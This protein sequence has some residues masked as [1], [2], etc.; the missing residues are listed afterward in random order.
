[1]HCSFKLLRNFAHRRNDRV[2]SWRCTAT[3]P[4]MQFS[5]AQILQQM[6]NAANV[7]QVYATNPDLMQHFVPGAPIVNKLNT[8][9]SR[10]LANGTTAT[11]YALE[12][13]DPEVRAQALHFLNE[14]PGKVVLPT[15]LEPSNVLERPV[16]SQSLRKDWPVHLSLS[17]NNVT[18]GDLVALD[19]IIPIEKRKQTIILT[20]G[21]STINSYVGKFSY[22]FTFMATV[23]LMQGQSLDKLII[24]LLDRPLMPYRADWNAVY[25]ALTRIRNGRNF[26]VIAH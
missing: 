16:L 18:I 22:D 26:R 24:S 20:A 17:S 5:L 10:G 25:V 12:W 11:L 2:I 1:M 3:F 8:S 14:N 9:P 19:V 6:S 13:S 23:H 15:G 21:S 7:D 4:K